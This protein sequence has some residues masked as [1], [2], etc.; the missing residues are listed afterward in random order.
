MKFG[1]FSQLKRSASAYA[2]GHSSSSS[3]H[4]VWHIDSGLAV[5][6]SKKSAAMSLM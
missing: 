6:E 1:T 4:R 2:D 5:L 3:L